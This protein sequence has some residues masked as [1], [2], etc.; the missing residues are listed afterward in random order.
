MCFHIVNWVPA[1][2]YSLQGKQANRK[3]QPKI[4][5]MTRGIPMTMDPNI[6]FSWWAPVL[7]LDARLHGAANPRTVRPPKDGPKLRNRETLSA[8]KRVTQGSWN[9]FFWNILK[10]YK[11]HSL[12]TSR[13]EG[14]ELEDIRRRK[15][16]SSNVYMLI[17]T[18]TIGHQRRKSAWTSQE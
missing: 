4:W 2:G 11:G 17:N 5:M 7:Q 13:K 1:N 8:I 6:N 14:I 9:L 18:L 16:T 3:S 12:R 10:L 15:R